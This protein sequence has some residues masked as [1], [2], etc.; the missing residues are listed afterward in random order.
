MAVTNCPM[1]EYFVASAP[2]VPLDEVR[3]TPGMQVPRNG[4]VCPDAA[5][6]FGLGLSLDGVRAMAV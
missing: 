6:G 3:L 1:G 4:R 2:G 5:P